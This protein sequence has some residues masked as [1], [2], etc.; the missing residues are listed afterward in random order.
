M[1]SS[2]SFLLLNSGRVEL[3]LFYQ[4]SSLTRNDLREFFRIGCKNHL[5]SAC[6][7]YIAFTWF[8]YY[9]F[10]IILINLISKIL[11][12]N[13]DSDWCQKVFQW[14]TCSFI[15]ESYRCS[16]STF[17]V[18]SSM[19]LESFKRS[20]FVSNVSRRH[21]SQNITMFLWCRSVFP[22]ALSRFKKVKRE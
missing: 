9:S 16:G 10:I 17:R 13:R 21:V 18:Y 1:K 22:L 2:R 11:T 6:S 20:I 12:F 7:L 4:Q 14:I 3:V 5:P 8:F 19:P 15:E